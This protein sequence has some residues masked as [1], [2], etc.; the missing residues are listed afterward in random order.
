MG[1]NAAEYFAARKGNRVTVLDNL[2]RSSLFGSRRRSVEFNWDY[3]R[4]FPNIRRIKADVRDGDAVKAAMRGGVEAVI[5]AAGQPGVP[6]SVRTPE[7]DFSLN[8]AGTLC[9]LEAVRKYS[10]RAGFIL[11]STNKVYGE[12]AAALPL[13]RLGG[14]YVY[15]DGRK[16]IT[17]SMP[18]DNTGHTPYGVSK[19]CADLY[20][21][22]YGRIYGLKTAVFRMS[23]IY[24]AR[25]FGFEDQGWVAWFAAAALL[26]RKITIYGDG[27]QVR[28]LLYVS[29][30]A[31]A[32][33]DCLRRG[34]R[35]MRGHVY[36]IGGGIGNS[37]SLLQML[38]KL[39]ALSGRRIKRRFAPWR[40][41]DQ[42]I[43]VSDTSRAARMLRWEPS[44][45]VD[46]GL[47]RL[48]RWTRENIGMLH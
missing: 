40:R 46:E 45:G 21:Q 48:L 10:P 43:Y 13:R 20:A 35:C 39:E 31:R 18:V 12:N 19:L 41:S 3:M 27:R 14:R 16:G 32:F 38:K 42:K 47:D 2:C 23:C 24:G 5:H 26:D 25:Q 1:S 36:N 22:E 4:R 33:D 15:A 34:E 29:D 8:A 44:V 11:C 37:F 30:L 9:L 6:S 28:D 17:E 7:A